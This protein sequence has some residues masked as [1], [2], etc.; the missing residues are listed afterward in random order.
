LEDDLPGAE[1]SE[2]SDTS[3]PQNETIESAEISDQI[4]TQE[5]KIKQIPS[6]TSLP[7][8]DKPLEVTNIYTF[9]IASTLLS[10]KLF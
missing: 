3:Q 5:N 6:N 7:K 10:D 2:E 4:W 1:P 8:C 9:P